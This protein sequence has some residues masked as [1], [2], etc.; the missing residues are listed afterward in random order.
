MSAELVTTLTVC[1]LIDGKEILSDVFRNEDIAK[2]VQIGGTH[3]ELRSVHALN[4]TT[5][6]VTYSSGIFAKEIGSAIEKIDEWLG[7]PVVITCDEVTAIQLP[8][9]IKHVFYTT[10]VESVVFN[11]RVDDMRSDSNPSVHS[12]YHSHAGGPAVLASGTT[13]LSKMLGIAWFS[14][15]E[16]EEDTVR[17]EQCLHS[18]SDARKISMMSG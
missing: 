10:G 13:F 8:Q 7:K 9:V 5:F 18:I 2:G 17:F 1:I 15:I 11:T 4:E 12:G 16:K 14:G 6:L 3:V